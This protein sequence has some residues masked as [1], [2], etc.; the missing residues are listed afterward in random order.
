MY[1]WVFHY[2]SFGYH[3]N[4]VFFFPL[5]LFKVI[6]CTSL[7]LWG[8]FK[9]IV[10]YQ[11]IYSLLLAANTSKER[12]LLSLR[13]HFWLLQEIVLWSL[14]IPFT[15]LEITVLKYRVLEIFTGRVSETFLL[16]YLLGPKCQDYSSD[17][18]FP[19][20]VIRVSSPFYR[21]WRFSFSG[22][23]Y[24]SSE[25]SFMPHYKECMNS[26]TEKSQVPTHTQENKW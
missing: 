22:C 25:L 9:N 19:I 21:G 11:M 12:E 3:S 2:Y 16:M 4:T 10:W 6:S 5:N 8:S 14:S 24:P 20:F 13:V 17:R 15:K 7:S 1:H 26:H 23:Q 18:M